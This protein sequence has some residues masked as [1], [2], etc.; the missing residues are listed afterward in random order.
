MQSIKTEEK[1]TP[2]TLLSSCKAMALSIIFSPLLLSFFLFFSLL[3]PL[4]FA[5]QKSYV[6]Y[7]GS[8]SHGLEPTQSDI[9]RV[10]DSHYELLGSFTE[11]KEKAKEKIFYS[12]TNNI[13]GFAAVLEEEEAS[14][15]AKH[16]DVVSV[17]LNK[18]KKLHTTRS[19]NF[20]GLEADGM[21]PPYSLWKKARYGED[22]IIGNLDTGVWPESKSFSD[23]GMGPVPSK[24]RGICQHD[25]KDGVVCNR[26]LIGTR[27]FNKGY[28]AYAGHLNSSF[29]TARDSEGHGTHTLSTA[30]GNFVPGADVLGYGNG[31]AKGGSPHARAAAYKVC[32]P[33][34]NGSNECFDADILAA[35]DVAISDGVDVLSVSLGGDPAE[36]ADDAI[37]IG[38][39]HAV[40]KG[41]TVV[42]SAGNSGPSPGT[43]SNVAPWLI[44]V[45]AS[46]MDRAFTIYVALGNRKHLKGA[47]LSEKRL[48][49]EKF[50]PLISAAD[51]KAADQ[52]EEDALL[53]KPGAL[54]PKKV[55]G[56]ILVCLR[57]E[58]GRVD[59]GHQALLA[60]AVGMIL[61]NDENSGNEII[62]DTHV[63]P[64]AHVN[65]TDG[66]AVFSYLNFTKEPM[67]FLTNVR[68]ELATKPAPF[69]ASFSSR[70]PNIIE[71]S[72][73]K[74]D[75][76]APGVSVIA[77]FTQAIGPSD[78]EYDKRRTP[79][80]TQSGTSMSCPHVSGI[81]GLLKTLHPEWSPAAIRSAI[82]TTATTRDNNGE[83]ILDSTNTKATPFADGAGHVQP[84]RAA[85]PGLI[86]DLTVNDFLNFLCNRGNTKKDIKL[87]SDKPYTCP[88][89]FSLADFNYPSIT[90]TNLNDSVTVTR[91]VKNVGSPGTYNIHIRAP[92]GVTVS[93]APSI[94]RFQKIGEE[95]MFK[96][97]FKLAPKAVLTDYVFGMLT[98]GDGKH[99][100]RS[101][102][103]VRQ[104]KAEL[105]AIQR[106]KEVLQVRETMRLSMFSPL[107]LSI[108]LLYMFQTQNCAAKKS[109]IVYMGESSFSP[110][111]LSGEKS[112]SESS[113]T[114][115]DVKAMTKSHFDML[116]T[117]LDSKEKVEDQ[118][119]YSYT[120]C[121]N[122][123]AAVLD[124]SQVAAL[125]DNPGVVSIF[126]NK[127]NRMYTTHSW[128]FLGFEKNGV[129]SLYSLQKK[130]NF[131]EDIIIGNLDSGVWPESKSFN[132][133]GMGP[134][135]SKWKGTCDD[136]GGVTCNNCY[137]RKLIGARYFNKGFAANNGPVPEE[138]NTAR[139]DASG[140]GTHTLSTAGG[141]Y[142]PGVNV[143]GVGNG[144]A[145]GGAPKARVATYKVCWPSANGGCTD[146]DILAAYDAAISDGVDVISVSLGSDEPIQ[147]YED[148]ISIGSLHAIKKGIPVIAAGGNNGPSD[149]SIT[150][151]AP[152]LFTIG[153]STMDREIFTTVTLGDKKLFK[154]KTLA[155]KN[156]PDG[157]LYPLIN[158]AEAALA[159][160]TPR[161]AQLCL[162]G[163][164]DPNKVS[165]KIIL[166]LRGQSPRLPKG[167]EAERAGAVGMILA[168]DIISGD[169]LYLEA[170]ELPS[171]HITYA[172]GESVMDYIK[173]TRNPT[174]SIS[175]AITNFGVKPSPA[176]AKFSSRGPSKI[177]PAV[178]K[179]D[180]TAPGVDVIAAFTE[181]IGPSR[182]PFD[183]R[184]IPYM[185][186]SGTSM[187]CP[188]VSGI[189]G[190]LRAIHP[191][192]SP[193]AL[194][195]AIMTTAKTKSNNKKR[196]LDYDGQLATPFMYGAGH[197][198]PN[199]AADPGLVYDTNVNDYLS[200]L[201]AHGYNKT[202]LNAFSDGPYTCPENFSFADFNYPSITVPDLKGPVTVTRRVKNVGAPGTYTVSIKA[203]AKVSVVVEPSS[204]EFKQA[205][206]E[207]LFKLTLEPIMDGMPK[208]YEFGH[209]TWSDGL[210]RVKSPLVVKHV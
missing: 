16:P 55:K 17:F 38:S 22:V 41:I 174:A 207:Q 99:F 72:I 126:E 122:G 172:D 180:I 209:L 98:W 129:P 75:I 134:V 4:T 184:R 179:P 202:L 153:A 160:A 142:V 104:V 15:L 44:T 185:V 177:E 48:P 148:G 60:G 206:E 47:S 197:V 83:P 61:A 151:G 36:F 10:T 203:P 39:F 8:H 85:D 133:E 171:A 46:T 23:E 106:R 91:R 88:K 50:Y 26:K 120:R 31:T 109:Y 150:N 191:D 154:G 141:S 178:L 135:P 90:V 145:K 168:N 77:A 35:F 96:V 169:E 183:K 198:Q 146:A 100:V 20:L 53:C 25:N 110:S 143:Y 105:F 70:G 140:H 131:G 66:E 27:Y 71:E 92:P 113:L 107:S 103:V 130:A 200:F 114:T 123:F 204:L 155:S 45:G 18:G 51:A 205:G 199:L 152:W 164:L 159:E 156:L 73:L 89:S 195:S 56:K 161:D 147:F 112:F 33:P 170:Y 21:V 193:A 67:A 208:D 81:V 138:W 74:P 101:P 87:F 167:Y 210:H 127:E 69:M 194:K 82:M 181:A 119:L 173:A 175:P 128:D 76:T 157:K 137:T 84:N 13:N 121:I 19:W 190:L 158:G 80:N 40:A 64:A 188:H 163:T 201:C 144:T 186:M 28:A 2:F 196:I 5:T 1:Q 166:C 132:D 111:S 125:N 63:L 176:M 11:G 52:S 3:Q 116:G 115:L 187:S 68:T 29:Q 189:V 162:D 78:A 94:L 42:A 6:V 192:W 65:F 124:E 118:M 117:Y 86:Y 93:V 43:V 32:W 12:Y 24:W 37:A 139:D 34:I 14:S 49:A 182:R 30:A 95:K 165:G 57:G 58:N 59:K 62:A 108:L 102:L 7:L 136:G 97:T 9:E 54:D 79:Y 149:G